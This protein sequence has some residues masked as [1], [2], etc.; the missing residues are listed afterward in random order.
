MSN[1]RPVSYFRNYNDVLNACR[2][3][4]PIYLTKKG[5]DKYELM[6]KK[7]CVKMKASL[8]LMSQIEESEMSASEEGWILMDDIESA[9]GL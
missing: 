6:D 2:E 8:K 9:F 4:S 7:D 3:T 5:H 1:I